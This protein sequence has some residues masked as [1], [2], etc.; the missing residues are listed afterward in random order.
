MTCFATIALLE[1]HVF[2]SPALREKD[3]K[4]QG[5]PAPPQRRVLL[6]LF[7]IPIDNP[8]PPC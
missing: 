8:F 7:L 5:V 2:P 1:N 4:R 3:A 6:T